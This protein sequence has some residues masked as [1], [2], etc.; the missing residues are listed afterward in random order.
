MSL[1]MELINNEI[2]KAGGIAKYYDAVSCE[3]NPAPFIP[4][5]SNSSVLKY[6]FTIEYLKKNC[7]RMPA[8]EMAVEIGVH[9]CEVL[10][11][12]KQLG[13]KKKMV[14]PNYIRNQ[15]N[16]T[17]VFDAM[18]GIYYDNCSE[19]AKTGNY[20]IRTFEQNIQ[21]KGFYKQFLKVA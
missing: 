18:N 6:R 21:R 10:T 7:D 3:A 12:L 8:W 19:A 14:C 5:R 16:K 4:K 1:L 17:P 11:R 13:I 2:K 20:N 9:T 15:P